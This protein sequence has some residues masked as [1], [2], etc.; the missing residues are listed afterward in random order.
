MRL[1]VIFAALFMIAASP[2]LFSDNMDSVT[3]WPAEASDS[4]TA[5][6]RAVP[7]VSGK[8][9]EMRYD[10]GGVSGYAFVRRKA[11]LTLPR[12]YEIRFRMRGTGGRNDLQMKLTNGDNV[13]WKVWRNARP[14]TAWQEVVVPAGEIGFAW[15]PATDKTLV[16]AAGIEFVVARNRDGGAGTLVIDDLRIVPLPGAPT[17]PPPAENKRNDA[18]AAL[19]KAS[20]RGT[21]P[22]AFIGEQP[23]WT[24]AGSDGGKVGA[25]IDEDGA[26]EPAKGSY[27]IVPVVIDNGRRFD[28]SN[29][30][31]DQQL[32]DRQLPV[33]IVRWTTPGVTLETK[34]LAD[35]A[36]RGAYAAYTL[37]NRSRK[38]R[39]VEL[40][41]GVRPWQVNPPAQFLSQQGGAS[42]IARIEEATGHLRIVQPQEEGDPPV[43]R[44]LRFEGRPRVE[45]AA[46]PTALGKDMV[47]ADLIYP[48]VLAPGSRAGSSLP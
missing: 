36:G 2:P 30:T 27:S 12:N 21:F 22:R 44:S 41:L 14:P 46:M 26:I 13:W 15:G 34:L 32:I 43:M 40:R 9:V 19:A 3:P 42:S 11:D 38:R 10:F 45:V 24:L 31:A 23:Y 20:P 37:T 16:R 29:A 1:F 17:I 6:S 33:P 25:L 7:G 48:L 5:S 35:H 39:S 47:G 4:V 8:A 18:I 28:W